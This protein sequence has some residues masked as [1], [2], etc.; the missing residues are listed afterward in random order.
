MFFNGHFLH[1]RER[2]RILN[3]FVLVIDCY[4]HFIHFTDDV[5]P[6]NSFGSQIQQ[7]LNSAERLAHD[8]AVDREVEN[9]I[10]SDS[11]TLVRTGKTSTV[12]SISSALAAC[13]A[14]RKKASMS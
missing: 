13:A 2:Y 7:C 4:V 11:S 12:S 8:K 1:P 6:L 3:F 5:I 10:E 9:A 14:R